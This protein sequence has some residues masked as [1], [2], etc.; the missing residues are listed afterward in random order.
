MADPSSRPA[1][2][3]SAQGCV[4][5]VPRAP[6]PIAAGLTLLLACVAFPAVEARASAPQISPRSSDKISL[7]DGRTLE[8]AIQ[9]IDEQGKIRL[10]DGSTESLAQVLGIERSLAANP[11][12]KPALIVRLA[13]GGELFAQAAALENDRVA[14]Q[15]SF[16]QLD[17]P[18]EA[19]R[20]I[21]FKPTAL[22]SAIQEAIEHPSSQFDVVWAEGSEGL[23]SASGL[24]RSIANGKVIGEFDG[25]QQSISES[26]IV[27][28]IAADLGLQPP[29]RNSVCRLTDGSTVYGSIV[30]LAE[31]R[32]TLQLP[33]VSRAIIPWEM[34]SSIAM[35]S[36]RLAWLS[37]LEPVED[38]QEPMVTQPRPTRKDRSVLGNPLTLRTTRQREPLVFE[39][40]LGVRAY[41]QL[42]YRN[43]G[44][45]DRLAATV[46]IDS[47]TQGRGD[48]RFVVRGDGVELWSQRM[49]A[50]DDPVDMMLDISD[51]QEL[52]LVVEP[53]GQLDLADHAD[54]CNARF[55]K[56]K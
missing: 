47:E 32:L 19:V 8:I 52:S 36:D 16:G 13:S 25:Q 21:V 5:V 4:R 51:V 38:Q 24:I 11:N 29:S 55:L 15:T 18:L 10:A 20:A 28:Y 34:V 53:G 37:D 26:R 12:R 9:T 46:G 44:G 30:G 3:R 49:A 50:A 33:G 40:G 22:T 48:C 17:L 1:P 54:W 27:A 35:T 14:L 39:K 56:T 43:D 2:G 42:I 31:Q 7:V 41:S 23:Q 6:S 45:F